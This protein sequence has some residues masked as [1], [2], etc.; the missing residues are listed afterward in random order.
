MIAY[1]ERSIVLSTVIVQRV[2]SLGP[3]EITDAKGVIQSLSCKR[4]I[5]PV[6]PQR[7][8]SFSVAGLE[9]GDKSTQYLGWEA[10]VLGSMGG[11]EIR[12]KYRAFGFSCGSPAPISSLHTWVKVICCLTSRLP[13]ESFMLSRGRASDALPISRHNM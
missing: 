9:T 1:A 5:W 2:C 12:K 11:W 6:E 10:E 3:L 7:V 13:E 4:R 8:Y